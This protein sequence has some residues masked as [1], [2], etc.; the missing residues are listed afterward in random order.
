MAAAFRLQQAGYRVR[1]FDEND[2][3]G[4]RTKTVHRDGYTMNQGANVMWT[5]YKSLCGVVR[6]AGLEGELVPAG[7]VLGFLW[8]GD[9]VFW[10]DTE[11]LL[12]DGPRFPLSNRSRLKLLRL[13]VDSYRALRK[14]ESEDLS[15]FARWDVETAEEYTRRLLNEEILDRIVGPSVKSMAAAPA[16]TVSNNDLLFMLNRF[17]G[18]GSKWLAFRGGMA[19]YAQL[20]SK[21]FD[22]TLQA[23]VVA[24]EE[25]ADE[26][27]V[28][29]TDGAGTGE[30]TERFAACVIALPAHPAAVVHKSL[31]PWRRHFLEQVPY[32]A[33]TS[34]QIAL[35][36]PLPKGN[37]ASYTIHPDWSELVTAVYEH[38]KYPDSIPAG[39]GMLTLYTSDKLTRELWGESDDVVVDRVLREAEQLMPSV[40]GHVEF[41]LVKPWA[42]AVFCSRVGY[43]QELAKFNDI[44]RATDRL[45]FHAGDYFAPSSMNTASSSGERTARDLLAALA[46]SRPATSRSTA[47]SA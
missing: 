24:V 20:L 41:A 33:M 19:S 12:R 7:S 45:V 38:N 34:V 1:V 10:L 22:V 40:R 25:F 32:A 16:R 9:D 30:Q 21:R 37:T 4:G 31:D 23:T 44:R 43:Y 2:Y 42:E 17:T 11:H 27:Q 35:D 8:G 47:G 39:K 15:A 36:Q 14:L 3:V 46:R 6:D 26:V 13:G 29:W 5:A 28:T 18:L